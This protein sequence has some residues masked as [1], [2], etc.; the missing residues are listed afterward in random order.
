M[1]TE[2]RAKFLENDLCFEHPQILVASLSAKYLTL[3]MPRLLNSADAR[4]ARH[5]SGR[6]SL[7]FDENAEPEV[8]YSKPAVQM[9]ANILLLIR[10]CSK[11]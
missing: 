11:Y 3:P 2:R 7:N 6:Y 9:T 10:T 8:R 4:G 1:K 5:V